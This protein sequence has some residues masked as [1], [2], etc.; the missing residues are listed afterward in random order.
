MQTSKLT[1]NPNY[2]AMV[3]G[4]IALHTLIAEGKDDS[5][6]A[7]AIRDATDAPW[8]TLSEIERE[9]VRGLSEDL[10]SL[11]DSVTQK[12]MNDQA[13]SQILGAVEARRQGNWDR[14]L[15]LLRHVAPYVDPAILSFQRGAI[16][17]EAGEMEAAT[18]FFGYS[19]RLQPENPSFWALYLDALDF[20]N[21]DEA[22]QHSTKILESA[23]KT[24]PTVVARAADIV[25]K[26][27]REGKNANSIY[28]Y[29]QLIPV[30][31]DNLERLENDLSDGE[32]RSATMLNLYLLGATHASL[33]QSQIAEKY[34]SRGLELAPAHEGFLVA[35]GMLL[36]GYSERAVL[37]F[38]ATLRV[39][40]S[41]VWPFYFLAHHYLVNEQFDESRRL[42]ERA[43]ELNSSTSVRSEL[44]EWLAITQAILR[45]P[46][47][48]VRTTFE[49]A[50]RTDPN[51]DRA[52]RNRRL[53]EAGHFHPLKEWETPASI[54]VR[55]ARTLEHRQEYSF[56]FAA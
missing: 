53:F 47:E 26:A 54:A 56:S 33:H 45:F 31:S 18:V 16:W 38:E 48:I 7:D 44:Y 15:E 37:D 30:L 22:K 17:R 4:T 8:E 27:I 55:N 51:N 35:R 43:L 5:P 40:A 21:P 32:H 9:R 2:I 6:E 29:Q 3:R 46:Q 52:K 42:C 14:A 39:G 41:L 24:P 13:I 19:H 49:Q 28:G 36:Y 50:I 11:T 20:A 10:Y 12:P 34:Y 25:F 23:E 1:L